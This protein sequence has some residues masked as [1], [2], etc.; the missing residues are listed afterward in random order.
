M[1]KASGTT[2]AVSSASKYSSGTATSISNKDFFFLLDKAKDI[3]AGYIKIKYEEGNKDKYSTY[4]DGNISDSKTI[5]S[6][7]AK[8]QKIAAG[9]GVKSH[10][11]LY[12]KDEKG[13]SFYEISSF[14]NIQRGLSA[15]EVAHRI[16]TGNGQAVLYK[17]KDKTGSKKKK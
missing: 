5:E 17:L 4:K 10:Y 9:D 14:Q 12:I 8:L 13:K 7:V 11:N 16:A 15:K 2:R 1:S 3:S 6:N